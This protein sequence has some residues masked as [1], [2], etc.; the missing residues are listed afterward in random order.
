MAMPPIYYCPECDPYRHIA[1]AATGTIWTA[2]R[3]G[4]YQHRK[5]LKHMEPTG[6]SSGIQSVFVS[7]F[8]YD[9]AIATCLQ[10]GY[11]E[12]D[13][14]KRYNIIE[15]NSEYTSTI[16]IS[17]IPVSSGNATKVVLSLQPELMHAFG[18]EMPFR[19]ECV[20]CGRLADGSHRL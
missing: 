3:L 15:S 8:A 2:S 20:E 5:W 6:L 12:I 9:E 11:A 13:N 1:L 10:R 19:V 18:V 7:G 4:K 17:G 16:N 14:C